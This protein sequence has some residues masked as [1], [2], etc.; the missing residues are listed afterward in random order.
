MICPE[1]IYTQTTRQTQQLC[2]CACVHV[3]ACS[4]MCA[5]MCVHAPVT[6]IEK[7]SNQFKR[8]MGQEDIRKVGGR[9]NGI[10]D[11]KERKRGM[12]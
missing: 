7:R 2:V 9:V 11:D 5:C 1:I 3:R 10:F 6:I 8:E 4:R 12:M